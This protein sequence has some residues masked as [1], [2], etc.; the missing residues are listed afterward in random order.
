MSISVA[1]NFGGRADIGKRIFGDRLTFTA[2][3]LAMVAGIG[4]LFFIALFV[5]I[6]AYPILVKT[7]GLL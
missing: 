2:C 6:E 7:E 5:L 3:L 4:T 1:A